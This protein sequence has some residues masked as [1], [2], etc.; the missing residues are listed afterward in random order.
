MKNLTVRMV[1]EGTDLV[2]QQ[3]SDKLK[4]KMFKE[5]LKDK[6]VIELFI[7]RTSGDGSLAQLSKLHASIRDLAKYSGNSASDEKI[8]IKKKAGLCFTK[9]IQ[10]DTYMI[11]KSFGDCT[12]DE[13]DYVI[14][15]V[16]VECAELG[17]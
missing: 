8:R 5:S 16:E 7:N 15:L 14:N 3:H 12:R 10:G 9:T 17:I 1:K 13:L 11:C 6:E 2:Y 4:F